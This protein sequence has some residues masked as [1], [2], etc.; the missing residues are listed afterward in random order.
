MK[1]LIHYSLFVCLVVLLS[2]V[3]LSADDIT[4]PLSKPNEPCVVKASL[5]Y[6]GIT[7]QG[8]S[9]KEVIINTQVISRKQDDDDEDEEDYRKSKGLKRLLNLSMDL[10]VEEEDNVVKVRSS[11][12]QRT[13]K[14]V[15]KVPYRTSLYLSCHH[16]GDIV[17]D[18]VNGEIEARNHHNSITLTKITGTVIAHTHH[19]E[20]KVV[21]SKLSPDKSMS[22]STYHG[23]IDVTIPSNTKANL[24]MKSDRGEI[25]TDFNIQLK[26]MP[27]EMQKETAR[28]SR[29]PR[30][31]R[32]K[33]YVRIEKG[34]YGSINGGGPGMFF[35][36]YH[37]NIYIRKG[38]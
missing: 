18:N 36:T 31:P 34:V 9:G 12:S 14:L 33:F 19:G 26:K 8:Y 6:G 29:P 27:P 32:G 23:D 5:H 7:V 2:S 35:K 24:K 15:I 10:T 16:N 11:H 25:Y 3:L 22:F 13:I 38:K 17:V 4:V 28:G 20:I 21:F 30:K 1:K 37:G